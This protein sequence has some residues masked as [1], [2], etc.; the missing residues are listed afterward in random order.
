MNAGRDSEAPS[1][2]L[3]VIDLSPRE[4]EELLDLAEL[5]AVEAPDPALFAAGQIVTCYFEQPSTRSR[6]SF[7]AAAHRLG[8]LPVLLGPGDLQLQRGEAIRDT[9]L[10]LSEYSS[11]VVIRASEQ[12]FIEDFARYSKSPVI[13]AMTKQHHPCQALTDLL[14][15][16]QIVGQLSGLRLAFVGPFTNVA[17]SLLQAAAITGI[18]MVVACPAGYEPDSDTLDLARAAAVAQG[19]QIHVLAQP[20]DAVVDADVVYTDGWISMGE[21]DE[22]ERRYRDLRTYQVS[23]ELMNLAKPG[24]VFMH[25]LPAR[26][27]EEVAGEVIDGPR[28]LVWRQV[29]NHVPAEQALIRWLIM[30]RAH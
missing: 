30:K 5:M 19:S 10:A 27:G 25:C 16:R 9:A 18:D 29:A 15:I 2:Y 28:S 11:A 21:E 23:E 22:A 14:T 3:Q 8:M 6:V 24:A 26:R 4:F 1:H 20:Q 13:N 7:A 17:R 12:G